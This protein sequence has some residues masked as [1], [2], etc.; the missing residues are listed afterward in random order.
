MRRLW[1]IILL[2]LAVASCTTLSPPELTAT[3]DQWTPTQEG[4]VTVTP[5]ASST[6]G[7]FWS[8]ACLPGGVIPIHPNACP[9]N[10]QVIH[11]TDGT[12]Q[13]IPEL[14]GLDIELYPREVTEVPNAEVVN[15]AMRLHTY[16]FA[17][18]F[19]IFIPGLELTA[20]H[21]Y[22]FNVP[23]ALDFRGSSARD[24][25][26]VMSR[27]YTDRGDIFPLNNHPVILVEGGKALETGAFPDRLHWEFMPSRNMTIEWSVVYIAD[28]A[29]SG[30][31]NW[32][33]FQAFYV[34]EQDNTTLCR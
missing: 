27:I 25:F 29:T 11:F 18:E 2:A 28:W 12:T 21:C 31:G 23:M 32:I 19:E 6:P 33:D 34:Q 4:A 17:G 7:P 10:Y 26:R 13:E 15:G 16:F 24:N 3:A 20:N 1:I 5:W 14:F 22:T 8:V 30:A 9:D